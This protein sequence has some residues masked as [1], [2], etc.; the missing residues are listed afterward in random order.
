[1]SYLAKEAYDAIRADPS[2]IKYY[3]GLVHDNFVTTAHLENASETIRQAAFSCV[4]AN[5]MAPYGSDSYP[6]GYNFATV[7]ASPVLEC[8]S[9]GGMAWWLFNE[10]GN[11]NAEVHQVGW[12][13]GAVG[14][15]SQLIVADKATGQ[16]ILLDPTIALIANGATLLGL[17]TGVKYTPV[18]NFF[19][20]D[21]ILA[22]ANSVAIVTK[23]LTQG[24][25]QMRDGI[26]D[27]THGP[28][29]LDKGMTV[30][31]SHCGFLGDD[32]FTWSG[33]SYGGKGNDTIYGGA[34]DD[35][36]DGGLG[37]DW[38]T[39]STGKD[40]FHFHTTADSTFGSLGRDRIMDFQRGADK[41]DI[42]DFKHGALTIV[43]TSDLNGVQLTRVSM[44]TNGDNIKDVAIDLV[45]HLAL[46]N[47]DFIL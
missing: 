36:I 20:Y 32:T 2:K 30:G 29:S 43:Q 47:A 1:M 11:V 31:G 28:Q 34:Y 5:G 10:F 25:Y 14:N 21:P 27:N 46:T 35:V 15:H 18:C 9:Y 24:L 38:L 8:A 17:V 39:G 19:A 4:I 16:S 45:G 6:N 13:G 22:A 40:T 37:R 33:Y 23:A 3:Y 44:D 12:D 7:L 42:H 41:I 26:Y